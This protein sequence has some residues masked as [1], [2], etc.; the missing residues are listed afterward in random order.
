MKLVRYVLMRHVVRNNN[1]LVQWLKK[2][3]KTAVVFTQD[4]GLISQN[5]GN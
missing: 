2:E 5:E 4:Y 3:G 1:H